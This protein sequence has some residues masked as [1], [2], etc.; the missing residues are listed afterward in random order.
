MQENFFEGFKNYYQRVERGGG[1][2]LFLRNV[3]LHHHH[4]YL[5]SIYDKGMKDC[6]KKKTIFKKK[7]PK[8]FALLHISSKTM[9]SN[10]LLYIQHMIFH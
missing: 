4:T 9:L 7:S 3:L 2:C 1:K 8:I 5:G 10:L 6:Y